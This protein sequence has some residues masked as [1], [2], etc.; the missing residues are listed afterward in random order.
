MVNFEGR[1]ASKKVPIVIFGGWGW[2]SPAV[3][4]GYENLLG[5]YITVGDD[6]RWVMALDMGIKIPVSRSLLIRT[7]FQWN[8]EVYSDY[9][10][11]YDEEGDT[12]WDFLS[13]SF[14]VGLE[15]HF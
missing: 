14:S 4:P 15:F 5:D 7:E 2:H 9:E 8:G 12:Q 10:Y 13:S 1:V 3:R 11:G 6:T